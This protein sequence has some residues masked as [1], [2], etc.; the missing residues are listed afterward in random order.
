MDDI[1]IATTNNLNR[2]QT[3]IREVLKIMKEESL[4]L[5]LSKCEFK[6]S[7]V[8]YLGL[9]L[10]RNTIQL[11]PIKVSG[12]RDWPQKLKTTKEVRSTLGLLN[13]HRAFIPGFSHIIKPLTCLLKK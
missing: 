5:K 9:I 13:Y 7:Q 12:L 1:L 11:D 10:D 8:E 4:F 3:I 6:K 2:H